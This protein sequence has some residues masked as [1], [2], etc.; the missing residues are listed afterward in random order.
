MHLGWLKA[1]LRQ[2]SAHSS[3][4]FLACVSLLGL[5]NTITSW[6][7]AWFESWKRW[8]SGRN[9][10]KLVNDFNSSA[11]IQCKWSESWLDIYLT[12]L[13]YLV[14]SNDVQIRETFV[15]K[16]SHICRFLKNLIIGI[17]VY[18]SK[19]LVK[20]A[21]NVCDLFKITSNHRHFSEQSLLFCSKFLFEFSFQ[22]KFLLVKFPVQISKA[23]VN[24][25]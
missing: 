4:F 14:L 25:F 3:I 16:S 17:V 1:F 12:F 7:E 11:H 23:F 20:N 15:H 5:G 24:V 22:L 8:P 19:Q 13:T 9:H 6:R 2:R 18:K 10:L 21:L